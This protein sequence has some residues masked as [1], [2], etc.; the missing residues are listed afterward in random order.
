MGTQ[1]Q[2]QRQRQGR[3]VSCSIMQGVGGA[4]F[5]RL[6]AMSP[7][8]VCVPFPS[9]AAGPLQLQTG[10]HAPCPQLL[11]RVCVYIP[12]LQLTLLQFE[13]AEQHSVSVGR[14]QLPCFHG[15]CLWQCWL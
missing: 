2:Q 11:E 1:Q 7:R 8:S 14:G 3:G 15:G 6:A 13:P 5:R 9:T 12:A 4:C 10:L